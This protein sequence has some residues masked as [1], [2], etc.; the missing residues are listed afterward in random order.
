[1]EVPLI[2]GGGQPKP[3]PMHVSPAAFE[4]DF[5]PTGSL[6]LLREIVAKQSAGGILLAEGARDDSPRRAQV[7][8]VGKGQLNM[9]A[10]DGSRLPIDERLKPGTVVYPMFAGN[11]LTWKIA[12]ETYFAVDASQIVGLS[13]AP[14]QA[15]AANE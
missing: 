14:P 5:E 13:K 12:D 1:M 3:I 7:I 9:R 8:K 6:V 10:A 4:A 2:R 15:L 11:G